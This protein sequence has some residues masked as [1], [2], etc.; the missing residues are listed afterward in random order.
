MDFTLGFYSLQKSSSSLILSPVTKIINGNCC[1]RK[2]ASSLLLASLPAIQIALVLSV[3]CLYPLGKH[4]RNVGIRK[5]KSLLDR[6]KSS[7]YQSCLPVTAVVPQVL[8]LASQDGAK[9]DLKPLLL[10]HKAPLEI[11]DRLK[12]V[13]K[14]TPQPEFHFRPRATPSSKAKSGKD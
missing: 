11:T 4:F 12:M 1:V 5:L 14:G 9:L 13:H 2:Q 8:P 7:R 6:N 3:I 10:L